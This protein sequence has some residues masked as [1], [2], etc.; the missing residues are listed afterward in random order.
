MIKAVEKGDKDFLLFCDRDVFGTRIK[1][2]YNCYSTGYDFVKFWVQTDSSGNITAAAGRVDGD[3]TLCCENADFEE[4]L[5]FIKAVGFT[6]LQCEKNAA[7]K[8]APSETLNGFVV[9][10]GGKTVP[11]AGVVKKSFFELGEIYKIIKAESLLGV[12]D[13]LP[14]LSDVTFRRNKGAASAVLAEADG[15]NAGCAMVLFRTDAAAL[16]GAVAT[17]PRFRGRGI[18]RALV[19]ELARQE[20]SHGRRVELLCK[21][22]SIVE[23]YKKTGFDVINEWSI[24]TDETELF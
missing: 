7:E 5:Y 6:T 3:M 12:G 16:L 13:Y 15:E 1:A 20:A 2:Y 21:N 23:F 11:A 4:L 17:V 24:I 22:G 8:L 9:R 18:A 14:W 19:T 10:Y